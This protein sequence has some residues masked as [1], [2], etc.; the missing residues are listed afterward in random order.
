N[1]R[2]VQTYMAGIKELARKYGYVKTMFGRRRDIPQ[3][4]ARDPNVRAEG[5]RI[6][7][8][9]P[10]QGTAADIM[11]IAMV[12][13]YEKLREQ[14]LKTLMI[15]Q[16]H[17][18][19][20]FEVPDEELETIKVLVKEEMESAVKLRVPLLVDVYVDKYML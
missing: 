9:T 6:A 12:K 8:N 7:I 19:L 5:E 15:L 3:I 10:I 18:E 4:N 17:D 14:H 16:V 13:I 2:G 20:I 1:Y 11:K